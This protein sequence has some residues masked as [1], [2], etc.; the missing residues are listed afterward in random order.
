MVRFN[1]VSALTRCPLYRNLP[2]VLNE[3]IN[4][5]V[6]MFLRRKNSTISSPITGKKV[7]RDGDYGLQIP[8]ENLLEGDKEDFA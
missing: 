5:W 7:N 8:C 6:I 1:E 3:R 4:S 2:L